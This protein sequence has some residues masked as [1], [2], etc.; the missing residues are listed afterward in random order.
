MIKK[1]SFIMVLIMLSAG[2]VYSNSKLSA[3]H[4]YLEKDGKKV[5]CKYC[6]SGELRIAKK[7]NQL[8]NNTLNGV[9]FSEIKSCAGAGC[10]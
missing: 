2:V 8:K 10:H 9:D 7:K 1:I 5:D 6:H 4:R 3:D